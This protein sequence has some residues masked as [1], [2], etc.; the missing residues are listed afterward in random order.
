MKRAPVNKARTGGAMRTLATLAAALVAAAVWIA[1]AGAAS[2]YA[3]AGDAY[4]V[5]PVDRVM[6]IKQVANVRAGP[7]TDHDVRVVLREG[8]TVR[9]IG[10]V[11]Y[12]NWLQVDLHGDGGASFIHA[13]LVQDTAT[14]TPFGPDWS[15]TGN[16]PCQVWNH[17]KG[18]ERER[19]TWTGACVDGKASGEGR[20]VWH[21]R[22]GRT[23][24]DG[25]MEAGKRHGSGTLR[26]SDGGRYAG[27]WR[28]G[29]RHGQGTY[30]W[31]IGHR[32]EGAWQDD[33]PHGRGT[34]TYA[35]GDVIR[36]EWQAGCYGEKGGQWAALIASVEACGFE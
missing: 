1:D 24:Y 22:F 26:R 17:G 21:S 28:A 5:D 18:D 14:V 23:V 16:Q 3:G 2:A 29:K 4:T 12:R 30:R 7:G 35:D 36:G 25:E 11:R 32:Y 20:L 13:S 9:V 34:A 10:I 27:E 19:F 33:R 6:K 15:V 31:A 8:D